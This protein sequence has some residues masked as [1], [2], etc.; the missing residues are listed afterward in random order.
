PSALSNS[1]NGDGAYWTGGFAGFVELASKLAR[2]GG[3]AIPTEP[4]GADSGSLSSAS[5]PSPAPVVQAEKIEADFRAD[6]RLVEVYT[7]GTDAHGHYVDDLT[8]DQFQLLEERRPQLVAG[9]ETHA[10]ELSCVLLLDTTGSMQNA[11]PSL[12]NAA[13]R[14]IEDL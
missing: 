1:G 4:D 13:L 6:A 8:A 14:L 5:Q 12:K 2:T 7:T 3:A 10:S 11:L 9:F